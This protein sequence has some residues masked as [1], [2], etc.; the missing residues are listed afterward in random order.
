MIINVSTQMMDV[1]MALPRVMISI[2]LMALNASAQVSNVEG[3]TPLEGV[4]TTR[5]SAA[6]S[7]S[8][9]EDKFWDDVKALGTRDAYDAYI[10]A[11]PRGRYINLA[12]ANLSQIKANTAS[13]PKKNDDSDLGLKLFKTI[14]E[15]MINN[16]D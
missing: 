6:I 5:P 8:Q 12:R 11:Y 10:N 14:L 13:N 4:Q 3:I 7:D 2:M 1:K 16:K 15:E 9:R